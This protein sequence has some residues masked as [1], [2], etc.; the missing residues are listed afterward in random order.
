MILA[1]A[2]IGFALPALLDIVMALLGRGPRA[3]VNS[4]L[5]VIAAIVNLPGVFL[6]SSFGD[7]LARPNSPMHRWTAFL[8]YTGGLVFWTIVGATIGDVVGLLIARRQP[9]GSEQTTPP[10]P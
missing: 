9:V 6:T 7:L 3:L 8:F 2:A 5:D 10:A 4:T 1:F